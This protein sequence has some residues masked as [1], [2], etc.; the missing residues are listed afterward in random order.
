MAVTSR[1]TPGSQVLEQRVV[2]LLEVGDEELGLA[3]AVHVFGVDAHAGRRRP[4]MFRPA[5]DS[6]VASR[7]VPSPRFRKRKF[8]S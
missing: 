4:S 2:F 7:N 6:T 1:K 8:G 5:P 3:V